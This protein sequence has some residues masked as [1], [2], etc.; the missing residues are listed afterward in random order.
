[1]SAFLSKNVYVTSF[2]KVLSRFGLLLS[3]ICSMTQLK[4]DIHSSTFWRAV[5]A[6]GLGSL[7]L[8][9]IG[10]G[11]CVE[12]D[13]TEHPYSVRVALAF[14][15][16][17]TAVLFCVKSV[18]DE[19]GHINPAVTVALLATRRTSVVRA[20]LYLLAQMLGAIFA[21]GI[22]YLVSQ[23]EHGGHK[24]CTVLGE[25]VDEGQA[26]GIEFLATFFFVFVVFATYD[27]RHKD[28]TQ[29]APF[30]IGLTCTGAYLLTVSTRMRK[31][32]YFT[33]NYYE[34]ALPHCQILSPLC[35]FSNTRGLV[36]AA[37]VFPHQRPNHA[38]APC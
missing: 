14:G 37:A 36:L 29:S 8:V 12:T 11:A 16:A 34:H 10:C 25:K 7:V 2:Q 19:E 3:E 13:F 24:G 9:L 5:A 15:L 28:E 17:Y 26:F 32:H 38:R 23:D 33:Y 35:T 18:D 22:V 1:M 30:I 31:L 20:L 4:D 21:A 27:V 6:E